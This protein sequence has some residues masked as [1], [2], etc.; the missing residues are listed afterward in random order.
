MCTRLNG[1]CLFHSFWRNWFFFS[2]IKCPVHKF[3][4][5][6]KIRCYVHGLDR[7]YIRFTKRKSVHIVHK[8]DAVFRK[9]HFNITIILTEIHRTEEIKKK[10]NFK[11]DVQFTFTLQQLWILKLIIIFPIKNV[12]ILLF[13]YYITNSE[14]SLLLLTEIYFQF[15][16]LKFYNVTLKL[17]ILLH[18]TVRWFSKL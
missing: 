9:I 14:Y 17:K 4:F 3:Y 16:V 15:E 12:F 18:F 7:Y 8:M 13:V 11:I 10:L 1:C 5:H 6:Y 2:P